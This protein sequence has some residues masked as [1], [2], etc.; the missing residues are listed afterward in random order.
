MRSQK[1]DVVLIEDDLALGSSISELLQLSGYTVNWLIDGVKALDYLK[2]NTPDIIISDL[3]MP[4]MNGE[5]LYVNIRKNKK[6]STVP[7]IMI[8]VTSMIREFSAKSTTLAL[9]I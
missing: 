7:F 4:H 2:N 6:F 5:Q 3:M 8:T 1:S 9:K